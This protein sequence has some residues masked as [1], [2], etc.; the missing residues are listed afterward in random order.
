M[1][2]SRYR[3][4][5]V[6]LLTML[7]VAACSSSPGSPTPSAQAPSAGSSA[8]PSDSGDAFGPPE[9]ADLTLAIPFPDLAFFGRVWVAQAEGYLEDEG[10]TVEIVTADDP[11]AA[12]VGGS[13][14]IGIQSS[15][16]VILAADQDLGIEVIAGDQCRQSFNFA[17]QP[18]VKGVDDLAGKDIVLAGTPGDPAQFERLKVLNEAGWDVMAV[19]AN[20]VYPGADSATWRQFFLAGQV[21]MMP[22]YSDDQA[23][24]VEYGANFPITTLKAWPNDWYVAATGWVESNP[25][26]AG[27]FLRAMMRAL[28][29]TEAPGLGE[30]PENKDR[31][32]E[33]YESFDYDTTDVVADTSPWSLAQD[34]NCPNLYVDQVA[35][36]TTISNQ[37][38]DVSVSFEDASD[39]SALL[40]AQ[41][42]L[43][44]DNSPPAEVTNWP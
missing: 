19:G 9:I 15:G 21:A 4:V 44:L 25:N 24:L 11:L 28:Q 31:I 23:A 22:Y 37:D 39:I 6:A 36:Q 10:L 32:V 29:F 14:D 43:G 2:T 16:A 8:E 13:A 1:L 18:E 38:L 27:R 34:F 20:P 30:Q 3:L 12:V 7:S 33:I 17:T 40:A 41:V 35:W 26:T 5:V 42:S